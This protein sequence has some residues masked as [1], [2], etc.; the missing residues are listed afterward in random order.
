MSML[1]FINPA[2][3]TMCSWQNSRT[4]PL[5]PACAAIRVDNSGRRNSPVEG[6]TLI[7]LLV[8]M[9]MTVLLAASL[10]PALAAPKEKT[11]MVQCM[12]NTRQLTL[13]WRMY[14]ADNRDQLIPYTTWVGGAMD[15]TSNPGNTNTALLVGG[16]PGNLIAS[17]VKSPLVYKCPAD[18]YQ[19]PANPG[20]RV[21]SYS[22]NGA[23]GGPSGPT[24]VGT[25]PG[26]RK[27]FGSGGGMGRDANTLSDLI[28][29]S[30][31]F[32][33]LDEQADSINDGAFMFNPG[34]APGSEKWRDLP[35]SYHNGAGSL[36]FADG[37]SLI[38]LWLEQVGFNRTVYP[39]TYTSSHLWTTLNLFSRDYEWIDDH[40]P[41]R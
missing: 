8:V 13:G 20:P 25:A 6:F 12:S 32:V 3:R 9:A 36:S 29:P 39:V 15:W 17:Y 10:L 30:M 35:A 11:K 31:V 21:R 4:G 22:M 41:Y 18:H 27:Y 33:M 23:L 2:I 37:H 28:H 38:H 34:A 14:A 24:V 40:M 26:N 1:I 7:D 19:S 5:R 16:G